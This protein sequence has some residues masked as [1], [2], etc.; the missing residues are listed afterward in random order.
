MRRPFSAI[1]ILAC[2]L[3]FAPALARGQ[4]AIATDRPTESDVVYGQAE[5]KDLTLDVYEPHSQQ[6]SQRRFAVVLVH[7]GG[8]VGGDKTSDVQQE[9]GTMLSR[10]GFVCFSV[11]YRLAHHRQHLWPAQIDDVQRSVRWIRSQAAHYN[12]RTDRMSAIGDSAGG[13]LVSLLGTTDTRDNSDP[14]LARYSSRVQYVVDICGPSDI[15]IEPKNG[16]DN[17]RAQVVH[18]LMGKYF[19]DDPQAFK[20]ASPIYHVDSK[21][22]K[23]LI[24]HGALDPLV[25]IN[26]SEKFCSALQAAGVEAKLVKF[27]GEGH[28]FFLPGNREKAFK[29]TVAFLQQHAR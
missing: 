11:N 6:T 13:H 25:P 29:L 7:G 21:S 28:G 19:K 2:L 5:G 18:D 17:M 9:L 20:D 12:I 3:L 23:F 14:T 26:Q 8:W 24:L 16:I 15:A 1:P 10:M 4:D 27:D 22:A